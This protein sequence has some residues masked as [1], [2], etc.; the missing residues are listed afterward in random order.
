M[1]MNK[2]I[3]YDKEIKLK[4]SEEKQIYVFIETKKKK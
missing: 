4:T 1:I 3:K 2:R